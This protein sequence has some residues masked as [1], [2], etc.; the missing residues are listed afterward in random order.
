MGVSCL[1]FVFDG[2][3]VFSRYEGL[4][5]ATRLDT[6]GVRSACFVSFVVCGELSP[7]LNDSAKW[8]GER[9]PPSER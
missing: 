2:L 1:L 7:F 9:V 6:M 3:F 4:G 5:R 8:V